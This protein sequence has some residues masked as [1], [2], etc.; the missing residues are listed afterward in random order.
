M[1][2]SPLR[3][4]QSSCPEL[5]DGPLP[6]VVAVPLASVERP[7]AQPVQVQHVLLVLLTARK[8]EGPQGNVENTSESSLVGVICGSAEL[9]MVFAFEIPTS[10]G[11][12]LVSKWAETSSHRSWRQHI[13]PSE[14]PKP[15][16]PTRSTARKAVGWQSAEGNYHAGC[17][18][19]ER[20]P[21]VRTM[22]R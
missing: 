8:G 7:G 4:F 18:F 5:R 19:A 22:L 16:S 14:S 21:H 2:H 11:L 1:S 13:S 9:E 20:A 15:V 12:C 6:P 10:A 17:K 3:W